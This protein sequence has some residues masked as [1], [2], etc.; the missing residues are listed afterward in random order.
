MFLMAFHR[1]VCGWLGVI[2]LDEAGKELQGVGA[3][4]SDPWRAGEASRSSALR[5]SAATPAGGS[6]TPIA[7][8]RRPSS[9]GSAM[10]GAGCGWGRMG[11]EER[12]TLPC[13][14]AALP[15]PAL[16]GG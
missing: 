2:H 5:R 1:P 16:G 8:S 12:E 6:E 15:R 14:A 4:I 9:S 13:P 11:T 10:A 3:E 7:V